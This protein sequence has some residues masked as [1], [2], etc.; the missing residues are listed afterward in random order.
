M[1]ERER[2]TVCQLAA[3]TPPI[4]KLTHSLT[5]P[6]KHSSPLPSHTLS[7]AHYLHLHQPTCSPTHSPVHS[8][9]HPPLHHLSTHPPSLHIRCLRRTISICANNRC[10]RLTPRRYDI[11]HRPPRTCICHTRNAMANAPGGE[12]GMGRI[13]SRTVILVVLLSFFVS[14]STPGVSDRLHRP[15]TSITA[16]RTRSRV[17][18]IASSCCFCIYFFCRWA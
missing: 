3:V 6:P 17:C 12:I 10:C 15:Y 2:K 7:P 4:H 11:T 9:T 18:L 13:L 1:S 8:L 14:V 5:H 16:T